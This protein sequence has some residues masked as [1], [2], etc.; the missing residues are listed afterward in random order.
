[1]IATEHDNFDF[2]KPADTK[3]ARLTIRL[4]A[5]SV[6]GIGKVTRWRQVGLMITQL[7]SPLG[8]GDKDI[9]DTVDLIVPWFRG[10]TFDGIRFREAQ[11]ST[12]GQTQGWWQWNLQFPFEADDFDKRPTT[13]D[14][15]KLWIGNYWI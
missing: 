9:I 8:N 12:I 10:Q 7:F 13:G 15:P 11:F 4:G 5:Q 2:T 1:M 14:Q 6:V 3:W